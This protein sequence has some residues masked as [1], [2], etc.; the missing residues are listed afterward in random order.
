MARIDAITARA[1]NFGLHVT[2]DPRE[3][4]AELVLSADHDRRLLRKAIARIERGCGHGR[5]VAEDRALL[6]LGLAL[7]GGYN[8]DLGLLEVPSG[9]ISRVDRTKVA[10]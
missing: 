8:S 9:S 3:A 10:T 6:V 1:L 5:T 7:G 2:D 4:A